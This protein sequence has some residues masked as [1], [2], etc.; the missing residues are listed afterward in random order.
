M[1]LWPYHLMR[2][3]LLLPCIC[4]AQP[5]L[6]G[7]RKVLRE[8]SLITLLQP[9]ALAGTEIIVFHPGFLYHFTW[10]RLLILPYFH[11][12]FKWSKK[13]NK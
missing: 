5:L 13:M 3:S 12:G 7:H 8:E 11:Q 9:V 6:V 4:A 2:H 10:E 1:L